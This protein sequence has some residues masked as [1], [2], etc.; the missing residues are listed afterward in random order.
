MSQI[1]IRHAH[2]MDPAGARRA[3]QD[4]A[5]TLSQR[6]GLESTWSG[7]ILNFS[8]SGI[9]GHIALLPGELHVAARLGF[10][11]SAMRGTIES[12]IRR[13]LHERFG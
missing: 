11:F 3:V 2:T 8:R 6:F 13:V 5:D 1:D 12:E 9:D 4:I 10:L 7:D